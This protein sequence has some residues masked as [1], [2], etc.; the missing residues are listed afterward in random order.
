MRR[1]AAQVLAVGV[2]AAGVLAVTLAASAPATAGQAGKLAIVFSGS[3]HG[4]YRW[5][6]PEVDAVGGTG[7]T[8]T[9]GATSA[10][11]CV[12]P[13][14]TLSES[15]SY[16][17]KF[18]SALTQQGRPVAGATTVAGSGTTTSTYTTAACGST[19]A[20]STTCTAPLGAPMHGS[21]SYPAITGHVDGN[22]LRVTVQGGLQIS[23]T[24]LEQAPCNGDYDAN[25]G[26]LYP[27]G[28]IAS[29]SSTVHRT[30]VHAADHAS[31]NS[32]GCSVSTCKSSPGGAGAAVTCSYRE[33]LTG[34]LRIGSVNF[35]VSSRRAGG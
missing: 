7:A 31:C 27:S 8:G 3:G 16:T 10:E 18:T 19:P 9:T 5:H 35:P 30:P 33:S 20:A 28:L 11:G 2:L 22:A 14:R 24:A 17:W 29:G 15:D 12:E 23:P 6:Q 1:S 21:I 13:E 26:R 34:E 32:N 25:P 4:S